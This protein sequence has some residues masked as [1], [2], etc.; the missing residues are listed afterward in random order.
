MKTLYV[1]L[2]ALALLAI[3]AG[4]TVTVGVPGSNLYMPTVNYFGPGPIT[5]S[6]Y[7]WTSTNATHQGGSVY[8]YTGGY[9]YLANGF[10]NGALGPMAGLNDSFDVY[11]VT[12]TMTFAFSTPLSWVGGFFNYVPGGSTPTTLAVWDVNG[13]LIESY[14]L[15]FNFNNGSLVNAGEWIRFTETIPIGYFTMTDNYVGVVGAPEP[16][17]LLLLGTGALGVAGLIRRKLNL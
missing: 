14:D 6:N 3:P 1:F 5:Y 9:G 13:V 15:T 17:S 11:G 7:T 16:G 10:W 2:V 4:A 12:D 8:G